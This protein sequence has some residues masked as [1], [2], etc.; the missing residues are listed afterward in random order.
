[1]NFRI[2]TDAHTAQVAYRSSEPV[3]I[4]EPGDYQTAREIA[5]SE[6]ARTSGRYQVVPPEGSLVRP[7][8]FAN[9]VSEG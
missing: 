9:G 5:R 3:T 2:T 1:M 4:A 8:W 7:E 6:S